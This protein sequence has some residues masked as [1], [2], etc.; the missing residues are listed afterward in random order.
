MKDLDP[1]II[2]LLDDIY[3]SA[4]LNIDRLQGETLESFS[5]NTN[6]DLK[7]AIAYRFS[8]IG[9]ASSVLLKKYPEF[10]E[11]HPEIPLIQARGMKNMLVHEYNK[12]LW[13]VVWDTVQEDL[14]Q[15]LDAIAPFVSPDVK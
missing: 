2:E 4:R 5:S 6:V 8:I 11:Q 7:D 10:C 13:G 1:R 14:P 12:V 3:T 9:E 15:I